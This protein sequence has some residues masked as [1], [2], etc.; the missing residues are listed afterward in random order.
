MA[1]YTDGGGTTWKWEP[2]LELRAQAF[3]GNHNV[4]ARLV[5]P[6]WR[7]FRIGVFWGTAPGSHMGF[8]RT[9]WGSLQ[10]INYRVGTLER[11][12]TVLAHT[13]H[14]RPLGSHE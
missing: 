12:L 9:R 3:P 10:G 13:A 5:L 6:G 2:R 1:K 14:T 11:N 8:W 4:D 7:W